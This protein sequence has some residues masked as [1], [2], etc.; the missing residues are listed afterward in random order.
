[1]YLPPTATALLTEHVGFPRLP[2]V[3][4]KGPGLS[5][6]REVMSFPGML[7]VFSLKDSDWQCLTK[8]RHHLPNS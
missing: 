2:I 3:W 1:M 4:L 8:G 7:M 5:N 6:A